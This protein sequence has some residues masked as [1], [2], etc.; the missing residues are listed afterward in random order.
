MWYVADVWTN[1]FL[2][3]H[4]IGGGIPESR[5]AF[6]LTE[7]LGVKILPSQVVSKTFKLFPF[8]KISCGIA[9]MSVLFYILPMQVVQGHSPFRSLLKRYVLCNTANFFWWFWNT[10]LLK[11]LRWRYYI[12][13]NKLGSWNSLLWLATFVWDN[14]VL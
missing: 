7:L 4:L 9:S 5:R 13:L 11:H 3:F 10:V 14:H 1:W 12:I 8:P 2:T 6:E